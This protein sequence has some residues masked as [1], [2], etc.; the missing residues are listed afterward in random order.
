MR[1]ITAL[2]TV[3]V[4][5]I[6]MLAACAKPL[7]NL[8]AAEL[9]DLGEKYLLEMNYEQ[10]LVQFLKVV[11]IEPMNPRGYTGAAEAYM[12]L[13]NIDKAESILKQGLVVIPGNTDITKMLE[14]IESNSLRGKIESQL[15]ETTNETELGSSF[16]LSSSSFKKNPHLHSGADCVIISLSK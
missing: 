8:S 11:E 10:A 9:L 5:L 1:R 15:Q 13:G 3:M 7:S 2:L 4:L 12:G 14:E 16:S 6:T